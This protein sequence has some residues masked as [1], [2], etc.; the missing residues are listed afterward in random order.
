VFHSLDKVTSLFIHAFPPVVAYSLRWHQ[1]ELYGLHPTMSWH[2]SLI[3]PLLPYLL[4]QVA[5]WINDSVVEDGEMMTSYKCLA[6]DSSHLVALI[7]H[8][9]P[10]SIRV[11]VFM[12]LQLAY[13]V[14]TM[15]PCKFMY[16]SAQFS[17]AMILLLV[18]VSV[19]NGASYYFDVFAVRYQE[20]F[21]AK[22]QM[23]DKLSHELV[24]AE[25]QISSELTSTK[26]APDPITTPNLI[27]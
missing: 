26:Q 18:S 13:T 7:V 19:W 12:A 11:F 3:A 14:L 25:A 27:Q 5:Y 4:W 16:E 23:M 1:R 9:F 15:I 2:E 10:E 8:K 21:R 24:H 17:A 22:E 6:A 20:S